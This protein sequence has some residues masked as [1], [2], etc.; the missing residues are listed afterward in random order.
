LQK[1]L[2]L[3]E[4]IQHCFLPKTSP[5]VSGYRFAESYTAAQHIGGDYYDFVEI[6]KNV[7][8][9]AVGDVSGKGVSAAL[10]MAKLTSELRFHARGRLSPGAVLTALNQALSEEME[11]GMFVTLILLILESV[12]RKLSISA[13]GHFPPILR[14]ADHS[15]SEL[16]IEN[17][18]PIGIVANIEYGDT[19]YMLQRGDRVVLYT[20]GVT[21]SMNKE[22]DFFGKDR[23]EQAV[24]HGGESPEELLDTINRAVS[25]HSAGLPQSD[26]LTMVCLAVD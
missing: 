9:I 2:E 11:G 26:D 22:G 15:V 25:A 4:R 12:E 23:L 24:A 17:N 18:I 6:S 14:S 7:F 10:Y 21:E 8:G 19:E 3:A 1:D 20:D 5:P 13:A 16:R